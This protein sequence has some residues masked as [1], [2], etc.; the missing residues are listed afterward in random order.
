[1]PRGLYILNDTDVEIVTK[2]SMM[3]PIAWAVIPPNQIKSVTD[4]GGSK[5]GSVWFTLSIEEVFKNA[6]GKIINEPTA[7][8]AVLHGI[9]D[10]LFIAGAAA[11]LISIAGAATAVAISEGI[12]V[13]GIAGVVGAIG[14]AT[15][16]VSAVSATGATSV[17]IGAATIAS[18]VATATAA[19]GAIM[20]S[21]SRTP[22]V[23][24]P[25]P[26][27]SK[28]GFYV[29]GQT[30]RVYIDNGVFC[31]H[32]LNKDEAGEYKLKINNCPMCRQ[33]NVCKITNISRIQIFSEETCVVCWDN[34]PNGVLQCGHQV[35]CDGCFTIMYNRQHN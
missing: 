2:L 17:I 16:T 35:L 8:G 34:A 13:A 20:S 19:G 9:G 21:A 27:F 33:E 3:G 29:R 4:C 10:G 23:D 11:L 28:R 22:T 1:M 6:S 25:I 24:T 14:T 18:T 5:A 30:I 26:N 32:E 12:V 7:V 15:P 31:Y